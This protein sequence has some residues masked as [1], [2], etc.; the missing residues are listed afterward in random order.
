LQIPHPKTA[1]C[2]VI[3][4]TESIQITQ[5][6]NPPFLDGFQ[7]KS[8]TSHYLT[9]SKMPWLKWPRPVLLKMTGP[10]S[11]SCESS[12]ALCLQKIN[13]SHLTLVLWYVAG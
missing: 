7:I 4:I 11:L 5:E 12:W 8:Q 9:D 3:T 1:A 2:K 10:G 6:E 13:L